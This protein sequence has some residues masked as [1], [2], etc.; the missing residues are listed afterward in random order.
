MTVRLTIPQTTMEDSGTY[1]VRLT[2]EYGVVEE[3]CEV[4]V[5]CE[6][7]TFTKPLQDA[8]VPLNQTAVFECQVSG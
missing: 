1:T 4:T 5:T 8:V 7:P 2:N 3:S 6:E